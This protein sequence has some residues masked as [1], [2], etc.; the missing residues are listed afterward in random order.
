MFYNPFYQKEE[1]GTCQQRFEFEEFA[2]VTKN[3][4]CEDWTEDDQKT[5]LN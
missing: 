5:F 2:A 4:S 3:D 1:T